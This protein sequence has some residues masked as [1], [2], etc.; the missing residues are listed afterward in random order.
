M[1]DE[2]LIGSCSIRYGFSETVLFL[3]T[4]DAISNGLRG[5]RIEGMIHLDQCPDYMHCSPS[6]EALPSS[7]LFLS[8]LYEAKKQQKCRVRPN[9]ETPKQKL[10]PGNM[11]AN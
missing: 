3:H 10:R 5:P 7:G 2:A 11:H 4:R 1:I 9:P 8:Y 6:L